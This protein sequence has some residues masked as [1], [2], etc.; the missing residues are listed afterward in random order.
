VVLLAPL[1]PTSQPDRRAKRFATPDQIQTLPKEY[2][3]IQRELKRRDLLEF[4]GSEDR[5][6][7]MQ[8]LERQYGVTQAPPPEFRE[9]TREDLVVRQRELAQVITDA[10]YQY[11]S[12]DIR[13]IYDDLP[14]NP[15]PTV[16]FV[17][18]NNILLAA[19]SVVAI[20]DR[21][22]MTL[23]GGK[24]T[25]ATQPLRSTP[26]GD[27]LC[28]FDA[29]YGAPTTTIYGT[30]FLV[31]G[32]VIA[33]AGHVVSH[34][35]DAF[36]NSVYFVF[37]YRMTTEGVEKTIFAPDDVYKGQEVMVDRDE[38][39]ADWALIR[40]DREVVDRDPLACRTESKVSDSAKLYMIGHPN[41]MPQKYSGPADIIENSTCTRF[42]STLDTYPHNS[43]SPVFNEVDH[44]VEG[45]LISDAVSFEQTACECFA[46]AVW[47]PQH[48][49][50]GAAVVRSTEF[51][52]Y[53][54]H[55]EVVVIRC[56]VPV[57]FV[58]TAGDPNML[59]L[60][61]DE[62]VELQH[63]MLSI[64][65]L[66]IELWENIDGCGAMYYPAAGET[67]EIVD[68]AAFLGTAPQ[69][70]LFMQKECVP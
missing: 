51:T 46:T 62:T 6:V 11:G 65:D 50:P 24:W 47:R 7:D 58:K 9:M 36:L 42:I 53:L 63:E 33:T 8:F 64:E 37:D 35:P 38:V 19:K 30:G 2:R 70:S 48:G 43:G 61:Q 60:V 44:T 68:H 10:V 31:Q 13:H 21:D 54:D 1:A 56:E 57:A 3:A 28:A 34:P 4:I 25:L 40:L 18:D 26:A 55:P 22:A 52:R 27:N 41:G 59:M 67:W 32:N 49:L 12:S 23:Q 66:G 14:M 69:G 39:G 5:H 20:V 17:T 15:N 16:P 29:T 45:I